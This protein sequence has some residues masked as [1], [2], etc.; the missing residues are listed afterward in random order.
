MGGFAG[1]A[2][3]SDAVKMNTETMPMAI[4]SDIANPF[5]LFIIV[6]PFLASSHVFIPRP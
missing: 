1:A 2:E 3:N 6:S 4:D 5:F